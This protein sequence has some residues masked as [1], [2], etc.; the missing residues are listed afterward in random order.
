MAACAAQALAMRHL[1]LYRDYRD[2]VAFEGGLGEYE[3]K[4]SAANV[5]VPPVPDIDQIYRDFMAE[6][7]IDV[8]QGGPAA[9]EIYLELVDS[10]AREQPD[11]A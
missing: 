9:E 11:E 4:V 7:I 3:E 2:N 5:D 1:L 10:H 8:D 6:W